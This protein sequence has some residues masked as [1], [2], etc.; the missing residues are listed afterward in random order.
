MEADELEHFLKVLTTRGGRHV[1]SR[2]DE[3]QRR[4]VDLMGVV[5][6]M[7][8]NH[9]LH[10]LMT[11]ELVEHHIVRRETRRE[12]YEI[13][14]KGR[15]VFTILKKLEGLVEPDKVEGFFNLIGRRF[16][17]Q[18]L[19]LAERKGKVHY[20]DMSFVSCHSLNKRL[21][22]LLKY[23]VMEHHVERIPLR[24]EWYELTERGRRV[25]GLLRE[26]SLILET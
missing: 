24:K 13:T 10:F 21:H 4:Y 17:V 25:I 20:G 8:L 14:E 22:D 6:A 15:E 12:W 23:Q 1:L 19:E 3:G 11:C 18:I 2:L 16:T 5:N 26:M 7:T 9:R